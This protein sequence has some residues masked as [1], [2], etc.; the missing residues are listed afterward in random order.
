VAIADG[1]ATGVTTAEGHQPADAV[2]LAAG[3]WSPEALGTGWA[4]IEPLWG[5]VAEVELADPPRHT[6]EEAG[7]DELSEGASGTLFSIVTA[8][9]ASSVG[10]TF[11]AERPDMHEWAPRVLERGRT[12]LP[13]LAGV[14]PRG[15]RACARP[16]SFDHRPLLGPHPEIEG[17]AV[18]SGHGA[19]GVTLGPASARVVADG[20]LGRRAEIPRELSTARF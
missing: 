18:A 9:G 17:L 12:F 11:L 2:A 5:V 15:A 6:I 10:S 8:G 1:R 16:L 4:P 7:I 19:W 20:I 14:R 3:P 13:M